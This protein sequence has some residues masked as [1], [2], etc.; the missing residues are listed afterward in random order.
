MLAS[1]EA[2]VPFL[3]QRIVEYVNSL[4]FDRKVGF[5]NRKRIIYEI[6]KKYVPKEILSRQK[7]GFP[8]PLEQ[9][10][11]SKSGLGS[12]KYILLDD[13]SKKRQLYN[14]NNLSSIFKSDLETSKYSQSI[15]FPLLSL[16]LWLRTF[17]EG[18]NC[19][20]YQF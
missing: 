18:D 4:N 13:R 19:E 6:A 11:C 20:V 15:I 5:R 16:E 17:I 14:Q 3:D 9:W 7:L 2:R 1:I 8:L 12:L 10:L